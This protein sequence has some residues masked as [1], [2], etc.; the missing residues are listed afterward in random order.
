MDTEYIE[1]D[2]FNDD[3]IEITNY[4]VETGENDEIDHLYLYG[5]Y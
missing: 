4:P 3:E 2:E 5:V 1:N